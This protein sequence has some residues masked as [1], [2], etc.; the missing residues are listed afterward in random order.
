MHGLME[1]GALDAARLH[2]IA[3]FLVSGIACGIIYVLRS[4]YL[5][6]TERRRD[7]KAV[8]AA[9]STPTPRIGGVGIIVGLIPMVLLLPAGTRDLFG[10]ICLSLIPLVAAG[11]A[12]DL[13]YHVAPRWR[14]LAAACSSVVVILALG[15]MLPKLD[16]WG[17][18]TLMTW[19]PFAGAFTIF[20]CAGL[21]HAF[22]LIDGLNGLSAGTGVVAALGLAS[23]ASAA[24]ESNMAGMN[25]MLVAVL[26]G[27]LAFNFPF[28]KIFLGDV[29]AYTLGHILAWFS[30]ALL[31]QV[32]ELSPWA[33][34]LVFFWPVADTFLAIY[35]RRRAGRPTDA[36][37]RLHFHQL[38]MRAIE[39]TLF[40]KNQRRITNPLTTLLMMPMIS[41]PVLT[42]VLLWN[43]PLAAFAAVC[44]FALL[45]VG[46]Y[47]F[48]LRMAR[49][50]RLTAEPLP[51]AD[52]SLASAAR[53]LLRRGLAGR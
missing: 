29:G 39:I 22:N 50:Y 7:C 12:E 24:G 42:G 47:R 34:L 30:I 4:L 41:A 19:T 45:F 11:L 14:L 48:G 36:P 52:G 49:T 27:F 28:G 25:L 23:I 38:A 3:V 33:V 15:A 13:G 40:G 6:F 8:Q 32:P 16:V 46:T 31:I 35:R 37:D 44:A 10:I 43:R 17:L 9:H 18:D 5:P 53:F 20:A 51:S 26:L 21:C 1:I 2:L